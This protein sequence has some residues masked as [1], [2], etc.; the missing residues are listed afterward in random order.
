MG[1]SDRELS[2]ELVDSRED[3][4]YNLFSVSINRSKSP[5]TGEIHEFQV[6]G[7]PDWVAVIPVTTD[8]KLVLVNQFRHGSGELSLEPPGG[9]VKQGQSPEQSAKEELE[10]ETGYIAENLELLGWL[11]PFPALFNNKFYVYCARD[12]R[13][14]GKLNPDETEEIETVLIPV[15]DLSDHIRSGKITCAVMIAAL[16]LFVDRESFGKS[17]PS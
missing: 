13:P 10:E 4:R 16:H 15:E 2:W 5:R 7:T 9:L 3:R 6:L 11:H 17:G 8:N 14:A 1:S 12:A